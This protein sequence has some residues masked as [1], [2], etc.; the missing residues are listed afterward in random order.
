[1]AKR[2][3]PALAFLL[4]ALV[5]TG[6]AAQAPVLCAF[7]MGRMDV[8][9][10]ADGERVVLVR[11]GQELILRNPSGGT[12]PCPGNPTVQNTDRIVFEDNTAAGGAFTITLDQSNGRFAPG[13]E[14]ETS[15]PEIEIQV[16]YDPGSLM[17]KLVIVGVAGNDTIEL[18]GHGA[19]GDLGNLNGDGDTNDLRMGNVD[20]ITVRTRGGADEVDAATLDGFHL[21]LPE[22]VVFQGGAGADRLESGSG[23]GTLSGQGSRDRLIGH[24][25][26]ERAAGGGGNDTLL[27]AGGQDQLFGNGGDDHLNGGP[28]QDDCAGGPGQDVLVACEN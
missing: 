26:Q 21:F 12:Y 9:L 15:D 24:Q 14:P 25:G 3:A 23:G 17:Q 5:P 20:L 11:Q 6:A 2:A 22:R 7:S 19:G 18:G 1:M 4:L 16:N 27:G 28:Q 10:N 8:T 13:D